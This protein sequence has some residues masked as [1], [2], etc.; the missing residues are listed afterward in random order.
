MQIVSKMTGDIRDYHILTFAS[1]GFTMLTIYAQQEYN[2]SN[3][4]I[5][6]F[7]DAVNRRRDVGTLLP[8]APISAIPRDVVMDQQ[9]SEAVEPFIRDFWHANDEK[10][11]AKKIILSF[12][13]PHV[14]PHAKEAALKVL[15]DIQAD[16]DADSASHFP[17]EEVV[18]PE[19]LDGNED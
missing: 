5:A 6:D 13:M 12:V 15:A 16:M 11:K 17:V 9:S 8:M 19:Y 18:I 1:H 14:K 3:E 7:A 10:I 2:L 4:V